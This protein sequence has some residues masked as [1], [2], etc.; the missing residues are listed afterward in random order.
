MSDSSRAGGVRPICRPEEPADVPSVYEV[1][2]AAFEGDTEARLVDHLREEAE[3]ISWVAELDG[4]VVGHVLFSP[5]TVSSS[6]RGGAADAAA[7]ALGP[8]AVHPEFQRRGVGTALLEA[9]LRAVDPDRVGV[10][11][12]RLFVLG[13][14]AFYPRFGFEIAEPYRLSIEVPREAFMVLERGSGDVAPHR[15]DG[16]I[17]HYHSRFGID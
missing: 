11:G 1:E 7:L 17:V 9:A 3:C 2:A 16:G 6:G 12:E 5:V 4:R 15:G 10:S 8:M 13:H 14:P